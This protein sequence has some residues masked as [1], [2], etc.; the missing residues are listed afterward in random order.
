MVA[1]VGDIAQSGV[2]EK[3]SGERRSALEKGHDGRSEADE[4][5]GIRKE[6]SNTALPKGLGSR[7]S[8][9]KGRELRED[10]IVEKCLNLYKCS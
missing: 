3:P 10:L 6:N 9:K 8:L 1:A 7:R 2:L 4:S 5:E